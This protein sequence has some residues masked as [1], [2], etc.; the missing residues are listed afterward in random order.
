MNAKEAREVIFGWGHSIT[1]PSPKVVIVVSSYRLELGRLKYII[2]FEKDIR[3][4]RMN[5]F[6]KNVVLSIASIGHSMSPLNQLISPRR[7]SEEL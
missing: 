4:K 6:S 2:H 1:L 7:E 5:S 3:F